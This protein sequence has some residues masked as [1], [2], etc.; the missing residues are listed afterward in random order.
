MSNAGRLVWVC[1][2]F[3]A[4]GALASPAWQAGLESALARLGEQGPGCVIGVQRDGERAV[5]ARGQADLERPR[6]LTA[7]SVLEAGSVAKQFTAYL[8]LL[9]AQEGKLS[10]DDPLARHLPEFEGGPAGAVTLRQALQHTGGLRDWGNLVAFEGWPRGTRN[11]GNAQI[12]ALL[13][14]QRA[15]NFEAGTQW[16]YS[17]SGYQLAAE[18]LARVS[19]RDFATLSRERLFEPLGL[20]ATRWR[21]DPNQ[22]V[23]G[24]ALAY[25]ATGGGWRLAMPGE[26]AHG[27]GGLLST[28]GDLLSW[29]EELREPRRLDPKLVAQMQTPARTAD[30][31]PLGYGLGLELGQWRGLA[32]L[33][34]AGAT[35]GYRAQLRSVPAARLSVALLCNR[36]DAPTGSMARSVALSLLPPGLAAPEPALPAFAATPEQAAAFVGVYRHPRNGQTRRVELRDGSLRVPGGGEARLVAPTHAR[37]ASG[38]ELEL[39]AEGL[40]LRTPDGREERWARLPPFSTPPPA[41]MAAYVGRYRSDEVQQSYGVV[42]EGGALLLRRPNGATTRLEPR[43]RDHFETPQASVRFERDAQGEVRAMV[44]GD[45]RV[46]ALRLLREAAAPRS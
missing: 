46:W 35:A 10:L 4:K 15:L 22:I 24:R 38:T 3:V 11:L 42:Q 34:H 8:V 9:M 18:V 21:T 26:S 27:A 37:L 45:E 31:Q 44:F 14:Q 25:E 33:G 29:A 1:T 6:P 17:N 19:G 40:R 16:S 2:L 43:D 28:V 13:A 41:A 12:R 5:A 20:H 39:L 23:S 32:E 7:D 30:G 36:S